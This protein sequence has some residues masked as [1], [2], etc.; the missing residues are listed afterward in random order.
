MGLHIFA[1]KHAD[2]I[3]EAYFYWLKAGCHYHL[4][5]FIDHY[6]ANPKPQSI[7]ILDLLIVMPSLAALLKY[8]AEAIS[9]T[10][11]SVQLQRFVCVPSRNNKFS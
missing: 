1:Y 2:S 7:F 9:V 4:L 8:D 3:Y 11:H 6:V 5:D 10:L